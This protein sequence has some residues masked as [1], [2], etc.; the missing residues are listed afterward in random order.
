MFLSAGCIMWA[1]RRGR[2]HQSASSFLGQRK[3][4]LWNP[5]RKALGAASFP[6]GSPTSGLGRK[7]GTSAAT[8]DWPDPLRGN[9]ARFFSALAQVEPSRRLWFTDRVNWGELVTFAAVKGEKGTRLKSTFRNK[10][11]W[12]G[13][14]Y[15]FWLRLQLHPQGNWKIKINYITHC[16]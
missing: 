9:W 2:D 6:V 13:K 16:I 10:N 11:N 4:E 8:Q 7:A 12:W 1:P 3:K 14:K 5:R 15:T